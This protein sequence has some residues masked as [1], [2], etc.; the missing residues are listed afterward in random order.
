MKAF[1]LYTLNVDGTQRTKMPIPLDEGRAGTRLLT[2][3]MYQTEGYGVLAKCIDVEYAYNTKQERD[4]AQAGIPAGAYAFVIVGGEIYRR[5][6]GGWELVVTPDYVI[7]GNGGGDNGGGDNGGGTAY[8]PA[9]GKVKGNFDEDWYAFKPGGNGPITAGA[10]QAAM[11][12]LVFP[13]GFMA[14]R[15]RVKPANGDPAELIGV[16]WSCTKSGGGI[17]NAPLYNFTGAEEL[18]GDGFVTVDINGAVAPIS[19]CQW[20]F[21]AGPNG[22]V[23]FTE[24]KVYSATVATGSGAFPA[25]NDTRRNHVFTYKLNDAGFV[26]AFN[27]PS[28]IYIN[29]PGMQYPA[30][31]FSNAGYHGDKINFNF[32]INGDPLG[33]PDYDQEMQ[34]LYDLLTSFYNPNNPGAGAYAPDDIE[35]R[36]WAYRRAVDGGPDKYYVGFHWFDESNS[37]YPHPYGFQIEFKGRYAYQEI[38]KNAVDF[39]H[40]GASIISEAEKIVTVKGR[41]QL[42]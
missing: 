3:L 27:V 18:D 32:E 12:G 2:D 9:Y 11:I 41:G 10:N 8:Y 5:T 1:Y 7:P 28:V 33:S 22:E 42:F 29:T 37:R 35:V 20:D 39:F 24:V 14:N 19:E 17:L 31:H 25:K 16:E 36:G 13:G 38:D 4:E 15:V 40:N 6:A 34:G 26:P 30:G 23:P 21:E